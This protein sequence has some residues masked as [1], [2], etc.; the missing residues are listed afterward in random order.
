MN[1]NQELLEKIDWGRNY[2]RNT[3]RGLAKKNKPVIISGKYVHN[4]ERSYCTFLNIKPF[5]R[6]EGEQI[7]TK[8]ICDHVSIWDEYIMPYFQFSADDHDRIFYLICE[9]YVYI[10]N[11]VERG[12]LKPSNKL[13]INPIIPL[14]D[15]E[16][17]YAIPQEYY[18]DFFDFADGKYAW[19]YGHP[20]FMDKKLKKNKHLKSP[21][22]KQTEEVKEDIEPIPFEDQSLQIPAYPYPIN[23]KS[24][25]YL[26]AF[27]VLE[28]DWIL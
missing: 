19:I 7:E 6:I 16:T 22:L 4:P 28:E 9:A 18:I 13:G 14:E 25:K 21:L 2:I 27:Q 20:D 10:Y 23:K 12:G 15:E 5:K 8:E 1:D 11:G 17:L 24:N 26:K 3:I